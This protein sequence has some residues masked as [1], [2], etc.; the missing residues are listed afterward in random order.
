MTFSTQIVSPVH[1]ML[2][3][4]IMTVIN[5]GFLYPIY[6]EKSSKLNE[7][8]SCTVSIIPIYDVT[9]NPEALVPFS[10][11]LVRKRLGWLNSNMLQN[12]L[13]I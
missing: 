9:T 11:V 1:A 13:Q 5:S 10:C 12:L 7:F 8:F 3:L 6:R 4:I 2:L